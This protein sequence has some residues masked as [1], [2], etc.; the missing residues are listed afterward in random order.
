MN[1]V[2]SRTSGKRSW[3]VAIS[4][5]VTVLLIFVVLGLV[6]YLKRREPRSAAQMYA[7][8][9]QR[10]QVGEH[11]LAFKYVRAAADAEP[12][13]TN[14]L[15]AAAI[16]ASKAGLGREALAYGRKAWDLGFKNPEMVRL[17][18]DGA[19]EKDKN[20]AMNQALTWAGQLPAGK[21]RVLL[22]S[23][24]C[25]RYGNI[26]KGI[27]LLK[28]YLQ[29]QSD[30][31][32]TMRV[33]QHYLLS[34]DSRRSDPTNAV[35]VLTEA[36]DR[37]QL[38]DR[39][40]GML[41]T[42]QDSALG[43]YQEA[44]ATFEKAKR[45]GTYTPQLQVDHAMVHLMN[46]H[47]DEALALLSTYKSTSTNQESQ[48]LRQSVRLWH[49]YLLMTKK[50]QAT[51][52]QLENEAKSQANGRRKEGEAEFYRGVNA[53]LDKDPSAL[54]YLRRATK[55]LPPHPVTHLLYADLL[56]RIGN[57]N[58]AIETIEAIRGPV[59]KWPPM[60]L[61]LARAYSEVGKDDKALEILSIL[62]SQRVST[63]ESLELLRDLA[64]RLNRVQAGTNVQGILES[65]YPNDPDVR[66][67]R[68]F[69]ELSSR[70]FE[71]A[72][73]I[74]GELSRQY[75][76]EFKFRLAKAE[77]FLVQGKYPEALKE[78]DDSKAP[79][80]AAGAL[81]AYAYT[82]L[83]QYD[84][85]GEAFEASLKQSQPA[86]V[87]LEY[88]KLLGVTGKLK[89]ATNQ[90]HLA[91]AKQPDLTDAS[92]G[93]A[94]AAYSS[95][96]WVTA[97][98]F[99]RVVLNSPQA[100]TE[101]TLLLLAS[102]EADLNQVTNALALCNMA[103]AQNPKSIPGKALR[104]RIYTAMGRASE[105]KSELV[106]ALSLEP[107]NLGLRQQLVPVEIRSGNLD[108][109]LNLSLEIL[110]NNPTNLSV[111]LM[112]VE[113]YGRQRRFND[114]SGLLERLAPA[115][116]GPQRALSRSWLSELQ[117]DTNA[118]IS[119]LEGSLDS[120][121]VLM[122]W[123]RL[124]IDSRR[125]TAMLDTLRKHKLS[126]G[127]WSVLAV[128]AEQKGLPEL[129]AAL[130]EEALKLEPANAPLLNNWAWQ[131]MQLPK[132]DAPKVVGAARKA[133]ELQPRDPNIIDTYTEGLIRTARYRECISVLEAGSALL[134][135][136]PQLQLNLAR[137]YEAAGDRTN[138][139]RYYRQSLD[140]AAR[141]AQWPLRSPR[142]ELSAKVQQLTAAK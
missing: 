30:P 34:S 32:I 115:L 89:E 100:R 50:D 95:G 91:L 122:Q 103:L 2:N 54:E 61:V 1:N 120:P 92:L 142:P 45:K 112:V 15:R 52:Q 136:A 76:D 73:Q 22:E 37:G 108:A 13:N 78:L 83:G 57:F 28:A 77:A 24:I 138:A 127:Q 17:F 86:S 67:Y 5:A 53:L 60:L 7:Q 68:G 85:A 75:P 31:E 47:N 16:T 42:I 116:S 71:K 97:R 134:M 133:F 102:S 58:E 82:R 84:K 27:G 63:R 126:T 104:S 39:G 119:T 26:D 111:Q 79:P 128:E 64:I 43:Q 96:N 49:S 4:I 9:Y 11:V 48:A 55:L 129:A 99:S 137:A 46:L 123:G 62:D 18:M 110:R 105:A 106:S 141:A 8:G 81:R 29:R 98:E 113:I 40:Y 59:R 101:R 56:S 12:A 72:E 20:K 130:Y 66:L 41:A 35:K 132:F 33:A 90:F 140:G 19:E 14:Y 131:A 107:T 70:S 38:D 88:G 93:L 10:L 51:I 36:I 23:D 65:R 121:V 125:S 25:A 74:F 117:G 124:Q 135:S 139:V 21:D 69:L 118:A 6:F 80:S 3:G 109:A 94:I 114:A 44:L 87:N